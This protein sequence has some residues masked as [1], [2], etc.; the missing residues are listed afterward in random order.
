MPPSALASKSWNVCPGDS[1]RSSALA[2]AAGTRAGSEIEAR[3]TRCTGR[4][5]AIAPAASSASRLLPAP[6]GPVIVTSLTSG[7]ASS[8]CVRARSPPRP[9]SRWCRAGRVAPRSVA[10]GE[11]SPR[12]PAR[13]AGRAQ[14]EWGRSS[15]GGCRAVGSRFRWPPRRRRASRGTLR[16]DPRARPSRCGLR[17][18]RP[19]RCTPGHGARARRCGSRPACAAGP[20]MTTTRRRARAA[21][22]RPLRL[23]RAL[24]R[25]R[26]RPPSPAQSTS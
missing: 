19:G 26:L 23:L 6:P 12:A 21:D 18:A 4:S 14:E 13:R 5:T 10:S 22:P 7:R 24:P 16:P 25:R 9:T 11:S 20:P 8:A 2:I 3:P 17:C 15:A 1:R